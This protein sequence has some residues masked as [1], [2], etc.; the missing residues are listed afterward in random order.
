MERFDPRSS[1]PLEW[2]GLPRSATKRASTG[3]SIPPQWRR[4]WSTDLHEQWSY[5]MDL[6]LKTEGLWGV[7]Y[8]TMDDNF[9]QHF[10]QRIIE[11]SMES[12]TRWLIWRHLGEEDREYMLEAATL[13]LLWSKLTGKY[14]GHCSLTSTQDLA[15]FFS[16]GCRRN[17]ASV[18]HGRLLTG[19]LE[20]LMLLTLILMH[21][22]HTI[23]PVWLI[24]AIPRMSPN[25]GHHSV[26]F[27]WG[28]SMLRWG[29]VKDVS[30][31]FVI[32]SFVRLIRFSCP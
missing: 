28:R 16:F 18:R 26:W 17:R 2:R 20:M 31:C 15:D 27:G 25:G 30:I 21:W 29:H 32:C 1:D 9:E 5:I 14:Q 19:W 11:V 8:L 13:Q 6:L 12:K 3:S 23:Y 7:V 4:P 24:G 22:Q 10:N